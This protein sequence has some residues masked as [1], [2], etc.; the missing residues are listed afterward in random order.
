M[1]ATTLLRLMA[2]L[3]ALVA[4]HLVLAI[5]AVVMRLTD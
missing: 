5:V 4:L 1:K 2:L 3:Y